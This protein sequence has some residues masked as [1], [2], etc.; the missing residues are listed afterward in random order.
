MPA[1]PASLPSQLLERRPDIA[2][3]GYLLAASD[4]ALAAQRAAFCRRST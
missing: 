3:A 4:H 1:V 2:R